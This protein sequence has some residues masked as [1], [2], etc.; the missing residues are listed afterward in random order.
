MR[1]GS[2]TATFPT[3]APAGSIR[4]GLDAF[5]TSENEQSN[6][7]GTQGSD[8]GHY[9]NS[10]IW[11][12]RVLAMEPNTH[13]SYGPNEGRQFNSHANER[14][15]VMGEIP[16]RKFNPDLS[17]VLDAEGNPDT[18]FL[19]RI[20]ADTPFTFQTLDRN[21][22]VLN[23]AQTWHQVRPGELR[24]DC[25]GCHA[26]SSAPLAFESTAAAQPGF[27][28]VDLVRSTPL[29]TQVGGQPALRVENT[30]VVD[31]EF[32]RDIRPL[33]QTRC[34]SCY[35]DATPAGNLD[36]ATL[37][38]IN[39][40]PGDYY[41]L[42]A[43]SE[44]RFGYPPV[45]TN[46]TW[47][48][49]NASRY[50]RPFQ[51]RRSLLIWKLF[52]QRLDGWSNADHP[53]E[54]VPGNA[55][56]RQPPGSNRNEADLDFTGSLMP[57]PPLLP[58]SADERLLFVRWIDL[59]APIDTGNADYGWRLDD[60]RPTLALSSPR[61][62][63][64]RD[65]VSRLRV[66]IADANTGIAAGSLSIT[67]DITIAGRAPGA[68]LADLAVETA[69]GVWEIEL[70]PPLQRMVDRHIHVSVRDVEG[71]ITRVTREFSVQASVGDVF[72]DS[73]ETVL[74]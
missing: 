63:N 59:G 27:T 16:L 2:I 1:S 71:N 56:T 7:W 64:N 21:G 28:V 15:R 30:G 18:S 13:R 69:D 33:L 38:Q 70:T 44:A 53:T 67:A 22:M 58:L 5:N 4:S 23:M 42:A 3:C 17:P 6:N 26:H 51:S 25:G 40:V 19:A 45:I 46:L 9:N 20:A 35:H 11:A 34:V 62:G 10:D 60:L 43:D 73:F 47:R 12:V 32:L 29:L 65:V 14:L 50:V 8:A 74:L 72:R 55:A 41:R 48:Q 39:G 36:L 68:Q 37:T 24:A 61:A 66:G 57:P 54:T 52:G 49:T 31:V